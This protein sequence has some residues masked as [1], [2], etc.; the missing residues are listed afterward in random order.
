MLTIKA[1]GGQCSA[2]PPQPVVRW[3]HTVRS[4]GGD[5]GAMPRLSSRGCAFRSLA[6]LGS[7]LRAPPLATLRRR[8]RER[9]P[10][11]R[12]AF[13]PEPRP[14]ERGCACRGRCGRSVAARRT[15]AVGAWRAWGRGGARDAHSCPRGRVE[16]WQSWLRAKRG[17]G[18]AACGVPLQTRGSHCVCDRGMRA[19]DA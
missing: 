2:T 1:F 17:P 13:P 3:W 11:R 12:G 5:P 4:P 9:L 18:C 6:A 15:T 14:Q 8:R 16:S 7:S 10:R 19:E